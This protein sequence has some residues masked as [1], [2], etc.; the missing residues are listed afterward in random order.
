M[1]NYKKMLVIRHMV[2]DDVEIPLIKKHERVLFKR[3]TKNLT[4]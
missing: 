2:K 1:E 4:R 3:N